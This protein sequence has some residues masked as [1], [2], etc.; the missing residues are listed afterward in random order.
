[1]IVE[2]KSIDIANENPVLEALIVF[3]VRRYAARD[4]VNDAPRSAE[5][6]PIQRFRLYE[7]FDILVK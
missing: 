2:Q 5:R 6:M 7:D 4:A 3:L 1:M